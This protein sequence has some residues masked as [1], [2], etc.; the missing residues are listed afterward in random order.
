MQPVKFKEVN[1]N[2]K[3]PSNMTDAECSALPVFSGEGQCISKWSLTPFER[4]KVLFTGKI[5]L[6]VIT[7]TGTQPPVWLSAKYPFEKPK[8]ESCK[9]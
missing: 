2:L 3:K 6:S 9:K 4:V 5:W 8:G 7:G 1:K